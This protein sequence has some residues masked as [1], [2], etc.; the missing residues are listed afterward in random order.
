MESK[1]EVGHMSEYMHF[2]HVYIYINFLKCI[3][4]HYVVL[5]E[6]HSPSNSSTCWLTRSWSTC[7]RY[8]SPG[9]QP[10]MTSWGAAIHW[11][12][13]LPPGGREW[14]SVGRK[15]MYK[16]KSLRNASV[17]VNPG[18]QARHRAADGN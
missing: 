9:G 17:L 13:C 16:G 12:C 7:V 11:T 10:G 2:R 18:L 14:G 8:S 15:Y 5:A 1:K 6:V 4:P 3:Y